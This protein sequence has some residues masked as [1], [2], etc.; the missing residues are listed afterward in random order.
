MKK[1]SRLSIALP[2]V[3]LL[4]SCS[5]AAVFTART[6]TTTYEYEGKTYEIQ[7][8]RSKDVHNVT[9]YEIV[10]GERKF[11]GFYTV[12]PDGAK[13]EEEGHAR[14]ISTVI[15]EGTLVG[16]PEK[17]AQRSIDFAITDDE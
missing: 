3:I 15:R 12:D 13:P 8:L 10:D 5:T 4:A 6:T 1:F 11:S 2:F 16:E 17:K 7:E 9:M 14:N